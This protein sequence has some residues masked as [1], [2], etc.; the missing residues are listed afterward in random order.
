VVTDEA[1]AALP[2]ERYEDLVGS[3]TELS[4]ALAHDESVPETLHSILA[5]ALRLVP[6]CHAASITVLDDDGK[7]STLVATDPQT[8]KLDARQ[9]LLHDGPCLQAARDQKVSSW[10][11]SEAEQRWPGFT[12][13]AKE[14][15]LHSYLSAGL[16]LDG[17][18]LGA[19]N[20]SSRGADGFDRLDEGLIRLFVPSATAAIVTASRYARARELAGQLEQALLSRAVIDQAI[21][22][23]MAESHC[24]ADQAFS[25]L[26]RASNNRRTKL[27]DLATEIVERV[28]GRRAGA[29]PGGV[30]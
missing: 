8:E 6:G 9:Y 27:R 12:D 23:I 3:L 19:L 21:G 17:Q 28:G 29:G 1:A 24:S 5:L 16:G 20:L 15:G 25:V 13:L 7:P 30:A 26:K 14:M 2:G 4:R 10:N 18:R 11:L 22:I